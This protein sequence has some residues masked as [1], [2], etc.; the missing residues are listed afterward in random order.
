MKNC[1]NA[2][3]LLKV[4]FSQMSGRSLILIIGLFGY[5]LP[6]SADESR[7]PNFI[8]IVADDLGQQLG[9]YGETQIQTP[10]LDLLAGEGVTFKRAFVTQSSCSPSRASI[11]TG[12]YPSQNGQIGLSHVGYRL[13]PD[14]YSKTLPSILKAN[15]YRVGLLG[16]LHVK[17]I[18][19]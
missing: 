19:A 11:L 5:C 18:E 14:L 6:S 16:K 12:L 10:T 3:D 2:T 13:R 15:G 9:A 7:E 17:P 4:S 1:K 8:M